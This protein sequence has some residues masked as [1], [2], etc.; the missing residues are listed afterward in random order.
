MTIRKMLG[1]V[2]LLLPFVPLS[3]FMV[4]VGGWATFFIMWG[5]VAAVMGLIVLGCWLMDG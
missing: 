1:V 5:S 4:H 2:C 3:V